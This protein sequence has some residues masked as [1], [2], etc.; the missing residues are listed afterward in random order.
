MVLLFAAG[1][2]S[3]E[4]SPEPTRLVEEPR[5]IDLGII[6]APLVVDGN[7]LVHVVYRGDRSLIVRR[8]LAS[9]AERTLLRRRPEPWSIDDIAARAGRVA[10]GTSAPLGH[11]VAHRV[12]EMSPSGGRPRV[13]ARASDDARCGGKVSVHNVTPAGEVLV[14]EVRVSCARRARASLVLRLHGAAGLR[15]IMRRRMSPDRAARLITEPVLDAGVGGGRMFIADPDEIELVET[16]GLR[17]VMKP[18]SR[19]VFAGAEINDHGDLLIH[20]ASDE[21]FRTSLVRRGHSEPV[22]VAE[23]PL[24]RAADVRLCGDLVAR[25][26][27]RANG[28]AELSIAPVTDAQRYRQL[29]AWPARLADAELICDHR[30][31]V[32]IRRRRASGPSSAEVVTLPR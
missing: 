22:A 24:D 7:A 21:G 1:C 28:E 12:L 29:R 5:T 20:A 17:Q 30:R 10:V 3:T 26:A 27:R 2:G 23:A 25:Y 9:G 8:D 14:S 18:P 32:L 16:T 13:L 4:R 11:R 15:T 6:G 19:G 31:A